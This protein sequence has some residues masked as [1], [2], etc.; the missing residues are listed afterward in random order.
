VPGTVFVEGK[1][2]G[3]TVQPAAGNIVESSS[4]DPGS[5]GVNA[6]VADS[7]GRGGAIFVTA[8][9]CV[10]GNNRVTFVSTAEAVAAVLLTARH[11][12][13]D[14]NHVVVFRRQIAIRI[15]AGPCTVL[16]NIT[17]GPIDFN[18][19]LLGPPWDALNA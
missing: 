11:V 12:I 15:H 2:R 7:V 1:E 5:V 6:N 3:Y 10:V 17:T 19:A 14:A 16:G 13:A 9:A 4:L 18:G 8:G